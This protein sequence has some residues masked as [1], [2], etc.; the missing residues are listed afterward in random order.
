MLTA[1]KIILQNQLDQAILF[2]PYLGINVTVSD[3]KLGIWNSSSGY[4]DPVTKEPLQKNSK[5]YIY[6]ITKTY[7]SVKI[8]QLVE[9]EKL[10]LDSPITTW[11]TDLPFPSTVTI[12]RLLN[13]TSGVPN[14]TSLDDYHED[15]QKDPSNP[16]PIEKF[17]AK[18]CSGQLDF[19]P[20]SKW[21]YSNTAY[22]LLRLLIEKITNKPYANAIQETIFKPL[23]LS[24][25]YVAETVDNG[26]LVPAYGRYSLLNNQIE[27]IN[28]N[29]HPGW[30][31]TGLIVS[32][33]S[34]VTAFFE[35]LISGHLIGNTL[36]SEM[37]TS[38]ES[39]NPKSPLGRPCSGLGLLM[40]K[41]YK[42]GSWFG[43]C[44]DGPGNCTWTQHIPDFKGRKLTMS[45]FCN[46]NQ[47][48]PGQPFFIM[49][50]LLNIIEDFN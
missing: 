24:N 47:P 30:C 19:E 26:Q 10:S 23:A 39:G 25:T 21:F 14:Y 36:F 27:N 2:S 8:L 4:M 6:S 40:G 42:Y 22:L 35:S 31:A 5:F 16:W 29:Y 38:V 32:T 41:E 45:L 33:T 13:H 12:R 18:T 49:D 28:L 20:G 50:D 3:E 34:E 17:M 48:M 11:L 44:G 46:T 43:H 1:L 7:T 9:Q 15:S 37:L